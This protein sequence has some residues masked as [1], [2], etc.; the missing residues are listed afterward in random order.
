MNSDCSCCFLKTIIKLCKLQK[1]LQTVASKCGVLRTVFVCRMFVNQ[2]RYIGNQKSEKGGNHHRDRITG[3]FVLYLQPTYSLHRNWASS[4]KLQREE[5]YR[6]KS[7][8][9]IPSVPILW[10]CQSS[11]LLIP[12][13]VPFLLTTVVQNSY[14]L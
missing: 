9:S 2:A 8:F 11:I 12:L 14:R 4:L 5:Q 10:M 13:Q 3:S 7:W 1:W 6:K